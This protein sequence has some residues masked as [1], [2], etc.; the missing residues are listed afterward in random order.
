MKSHRFCNRFA[1]AIVVGF[2]LSV[3][4]A[5]QSVLA[6]G[7][8]GV[9][10]LLIQQ[11]FDRGGRWYLIDDGGCFT[12]LESPHTQLVRGRLVLHAH[13][14]S[15]LGQPM[16]N[17]CVGSD[18]ASD[19]T[20]S[21]RLHGSGHLLILD[22]IRIDRIDDESTRDALNL[23]LQVDPQILPHA[24]NID[25]SE[26]VRQQVVAVGGSRTRLDGFRILNITTR[27]D[28]VVIEFDLRLSVP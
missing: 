28:A 22:D 6:V 16:G 23:A 4:A 27:A 1:L 21:G 26:F 25:V 13:L 10:T 5:A 9:Q 15:R 18:F 2:V 8:R 11:L 12:Y 20:L 3:P 14:S 19:V 7:P 24:A 17:E